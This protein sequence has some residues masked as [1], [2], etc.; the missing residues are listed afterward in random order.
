MRCCLLVRATG[1]EPACRK[2]YEPKSYVSTSST[3][4]AYEVDPQIFTLGGT[5]GGAQSLIRSAVIFTRHSCRG[6]AVYALS[7]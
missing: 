3:T 5:R 2:T 6:G 4:P 1:L 7:R